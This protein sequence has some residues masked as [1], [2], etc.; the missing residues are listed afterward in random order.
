MNASLYTQTLLKDD[1]LSQGAWQEPKKKKDY[2]TT[3]LILYINHTLLEKKCKPGNF[4][5][6]SDY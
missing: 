6:G 3:T 5:G 1:S 4:S 2:M